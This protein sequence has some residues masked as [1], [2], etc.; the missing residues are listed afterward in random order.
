MNSKM[1]SVV[2]HAAKCVELSGALPQK[3]HVG[4]S[5][6][7]FAVAILLCRM[8]LKSLTHHE[9]RHPGSAKRPGGLPAEQH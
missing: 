1:G 8:C 4:S 2:M 6:N 9:P 7:L 3:R 5:A